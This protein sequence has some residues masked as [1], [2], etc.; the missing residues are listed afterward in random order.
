MGR[1]VIRS[2]KAAAIQELTGKRNIFPEVPPLFCPLDA[3]SVNIS[4]QVRPS[5]LFMSPE[6][7]VSHL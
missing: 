1:R 7:R 6:Y 4:A 5:K 2:F 3:V